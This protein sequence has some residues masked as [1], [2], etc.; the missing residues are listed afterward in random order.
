MMISCVQI[1]QTVEILHNWVK[2]RKIILLNYF[3]N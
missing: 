2:Y 3:N 1:P